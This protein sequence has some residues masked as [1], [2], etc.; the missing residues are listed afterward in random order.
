MMVFLRDFC[1]APRWTVVVFAMPQVGA[2]SDGH[3]SCP[4]AVYRLTV[5][6]RAAKYLKTLSSLSLWI[7]G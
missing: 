6:H 2:R 4:H 1:P 7:N 5:S 3:G